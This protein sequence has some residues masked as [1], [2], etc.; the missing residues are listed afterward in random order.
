MYG[1]NTLDYASGET[2]WLPQSHCGPSA[3]VCVQ[4]NGE[5]QAIP[6]LTEWCWSRAC[7]DFRAAV[8][9]SA[10]PTSPPWPP[11]PPGPP[12]APL[13]PS[14]PPDPPLPPP[15]PPLPPPLPSSPPSPPSPPLAPSICVGDAP[16]L[17]DQCFTIGATCC[18]ITVSCK[19]AGGGR[20][21]C[22]PS[23]TQSDAV[24]S[25][26]CRG[27]GTALYG[28][29]T[30]DDDC[31]ELDIERP[32]CYD[33]GSSGGKCLVATESDPT[34]CLCYSATGVETASCLPNLNK[35]QNDAS[36]LKFSLRSYFG[37][38]DDG[39]VQKA[40]ADNSG[41]YC[42]DSEGSPQGKF[43]CPSADPTQCS[44]TQ[45]EGVDGSGCMQVF[46]TT[47]PTPWP[48]SYENLCALQ[49]QDKTGP[50]PIKWSDFFA[51][52]VYSSSSP[53]PVTVVS[54]AST[55]KG[56]IYASNTNTIQQNDGYWCASKTGY[57]PS[58]PPEPSCVQQYQS[59]CTATKPCCGNFECFDF[60]K[61]NEGFAQCFQSVADCKLNIGGHPLVWCDQVN[62]ANQ[63]AT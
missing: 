2:T 58:E 31:C 55:T 46:V 11:S 59:G 60:H 10:P 32:V 39:G 20:K 17:E 8:N 23:S 37:G 34:I 47:P 14:Y 36:N 33:D 28:K 52:R 61:I 48:T 38:C 29:C 12:F 30:I 27:S 25:A 51:K 26:G 18:P 41:F 3:E 56:A 45:D 6:G 63:T 57:L 40:F 49:C 44:A 35:C 24:S 13:S 43:F 15:D 7:S 22:T 4:Q 53:L 50:R 16:M 5:T 42:A 1:G 62:P 9:A 21:Q 54:N 19:D